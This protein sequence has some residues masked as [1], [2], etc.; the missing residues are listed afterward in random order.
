MACRRSSWIEPGRGRD[1]QGKAL[2]TPAARASFRT[3]L[4]SSLH[5]SR[6]HS[7]TWSLLEVGR[8]DESSTMSLRGCREV[9][10]CSDTGFKA[11]LAP[12]R[13]NSVRLELIDRKSTRLNSS[14]LV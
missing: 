5:P 12:S 11:C 13:S 7:V 10:C 3:D 4:S 6:T 2:F 1:P 14:H 8:L 9:P